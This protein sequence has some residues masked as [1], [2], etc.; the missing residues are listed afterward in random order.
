MPACFSKLAQFQTFSPGLKQM[1]VVDSLG[2]A[3]SQY[4]DLVLINLNEQ[5]LGCWPPDGAKDLKQTCNTQV[6]V[7]GS[8]AG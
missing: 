7:T 4:F 8:S 5:K 6:S 3:F 2:V 1:R